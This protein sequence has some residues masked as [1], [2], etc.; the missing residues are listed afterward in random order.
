MKIIIENVSSRV[1][2]GGKD[3]LL[4][5]DIMKELKKMLRIR[6]DGYERTPAYKQR[7]WDGYTSLITAKGVFATG[8]VFSVI[9]KM[10]ELGV[11][12]EVIDERTNMPVF[13]STLCSDVGNGWTG[14]P[15]QLEAVRSIYKSFKIGGK[16][17]PWYRGTVDIATNGGK[18]SICALLLG[19][20]KFRKCLYLVDRVAN[21]EQT[22][23]FYEQMF[24][25]S[26]LNSKHDDFNGD[27]VVGMIGSVKSKMDK[28][29]NVLAKLKNDFDV[30]IVD[31]SHRASSATYLKVLA[32]VNAGCRLALSGTNYDIDSKYKK[33]MLI[34]SFGKSLVKIT[35]A[36]LIEKG[37][38]LKPTVY[39][40]L[41]DYCR[42]IQTLGYEDEYKKSV[43]QSTARIHTMKELISDGKSSLIAVRYKEHAKLLYETLQTNGL[44]VEYSHGQDKDRRDKLQRFKTGEINVLI[45]TSITQESLNIPIIRRICYALGGKSKSGMKQYYGRGA[46]LYEGYEGLEMHDFWDLGST[47]SKHSRY[48]I[49]GWKNE[50]FDVEFKYEHNQHYSPK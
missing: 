13:L 46:R 14:Y 11:G 20:M 43:I 44:V 9:K 36:F 15:E 29:I 18:L 12:V 16:I 45:S 5:I 19:N 21:F 17:I 38:S 41:N 4:D 27:L 35:N 47:V 6:K 3:N 39:I 23:E 40:H 7:R 28:S 49:K 10:R 24:N 34:A 25:V 1:V 50:G 2:I 42:N 26:K 22:I 31:E 48:R 33:L 30:V 32:N 37:R 8:F